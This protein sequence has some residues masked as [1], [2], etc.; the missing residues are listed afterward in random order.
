MRNGTARA[1]SED[2]WS[3][4]SAQQHNAP[5]PFGGEA[6]PNWLSAITEIARSHI[7]PL[8]FPRQ[9]ALEC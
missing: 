8:L 7:R 1:E 6:R 5:S 3:G 2:L 9:S 4:G